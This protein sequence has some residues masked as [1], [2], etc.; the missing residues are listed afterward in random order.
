[1]QTPT[2]QDPNKPTIEMSLREHLLAA[3][4]GQPTVQ[5]LPQ[6]PA[7][8]QHAQHPHTTG[9][10][11]AI[12][13]AIGGSYDM[14][15]GGPDDGNSSEGRS[16]GRRELSTS[17]RAAQNRAA[18]RAFR[19]RKEEYIKQL[20]DQVKEFEQLCELYKTLQTE[21]YQLRDYIINL[22]SRLLETQG[23]IPPAPAGVDLNRP[24]GDQATM[25][26]PPEAPQ[27]PPQQQPEPQHPN[28]SPNNNTGGL[29]ER[30]IGELQMAAQ[31]AA[32]AQHGTAGSKHPNSDSSYDYTEKRQKV[33]ES[34]QGQQPSSSF[35]SNSNAY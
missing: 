30:Q 23:E 1:M 29:S 28:Q 22:Q 19:Q 5:P 34:H 9:P 8:A 27:P 17:K 12:D 24:L 26:Q 20:K 18:Q 3:G 7:H 31:A 10:P 16:K 4:A 15:A 13:P 25:H 21:N 6:H 33:D 35:Y 32:A 2:A 14:S 11:H